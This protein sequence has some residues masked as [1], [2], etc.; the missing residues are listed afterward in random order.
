MARTF[1][2]HPGKGPKK[3]PKLELPEGGTVRIKQVR[4]GIGHS[5][6]MRQTLEAMGLKHHQDVV[7]QKVTPG[8]VGQIKRVRHLVEVTPVEEG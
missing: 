7:V 5:W 6:R 8:L 2:W 3:T 1:V 4:S